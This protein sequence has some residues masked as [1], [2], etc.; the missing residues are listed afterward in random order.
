MLDETKPTPSNYREQLA[1][2]GDA[3]HNYTYEKIL[4]QWNN[5][6]KVVDKIPNKREH[7]FGTSWSSIAVE[8]LMNKIQDLQLELDN[9]SLVIKDLL[10]M[11]DNG[12]NTNSR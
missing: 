5:F 12:Y 3:V 9:K 1:F 4:D 8:I 2:T 11:I 7:W 10:R 6:I